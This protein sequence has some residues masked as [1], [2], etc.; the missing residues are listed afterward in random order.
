MHEVAED[1]SARALE[2]ARTV[3]GF[4]PTAVQKGMAFVQQVQGLGSEEAG[5][6]AREVRNQVFSGEDFQE[7]MR[8]FREKRSPRWPSSAG[9]MLK[10]DRHSI[11]V[12]MRYYILWCRAVGTLWVGV[13]VLY[14][15]AK[16]V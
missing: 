7:G 1:A 5:A 11:F 12:D 15:C 16:R 4:S 2:I 14:F 9:E 13:E 8:A 3:A 10:V 6:V